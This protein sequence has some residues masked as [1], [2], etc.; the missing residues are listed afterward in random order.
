MFLCSRSREDGGATREKDKERARSSGGGGKRHGDADVVL[1][2]SPSDSSVHRS[3]FDPKYSSS[4]KS[5]KNL[6]SSAP[7]SSK[8]MKV[9]SEKGS[10]DF[11][12]SK[13]RSNNNGKADDRWDMSSDSHHR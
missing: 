11:V 7:S 3:Y 5:G 4:D 8:V 12:T 9:I 13:N 10:K 2:S 1:K 6:S